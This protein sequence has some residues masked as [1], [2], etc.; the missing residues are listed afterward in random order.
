MPIKKTILRQII[1]N[2][3]TATIHF[4]CAAVELTELRIACMRR[5]I[6]PQQFFV[7]VVSRVANG[8]T[9][10]LSIMDDC[11][12][13][14]RKKTIDKLY[15]EL[16][17]EGIYDLINLTGAAKRDHIKAKAEINK[18]KRQTKKFF[19]EDEEKNRALYDKKEIQDLVYN[20]RGDQAALLK[21]LEENGDEDD[22]D[23][24]GDLDESEDS[25][26]GDF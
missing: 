19:Q 21:D 17:A 4:D 8:D 10:L 9:A 18:E 3:T 15:C 20:R 25:E 11:R 7:E 14:K 12:E 22:L 26:T 6:T 1:N 16:E 23:G 13:L 24:D 2:E 5:R